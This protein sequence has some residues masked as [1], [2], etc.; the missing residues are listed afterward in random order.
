[1][2]GRRLV[3]NLPWYVPLPATVILLGLLAGLNVALSKYFEV[4][5]DMIWP[6]YLAISIV[7]MCSAVIGAFV[8]RLTASQQLVQ[9]ENEINSRYDNLK[10]LI[11]SVEREIKSIKTQSS[12]CNGYGNSLSLSISTLKQII[13]GEFGDSLITYEELKQI[14]NAIP[15]NRQIWVLTSALELED[16]ELKKVIISNFKR[17]VIYKYLIPAEDKVLQQ[18][19]KTLAIDWQQSSGLSV[20]Q[21][22]KQILCYLVPKH[23]VYMTVIIYDPFKTPP[24]VLVKFPTSEFYQKEKYPL[25]YRVDSKPKEAWHI[26][27]EAFQDLIDD[28]RKCSLTTPMVFEFKESTK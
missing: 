16:N 19:M 27:I 20:E 10:L 3:L 18:K 24:A 11:E 28:G 5:P 25:I 14:E 23:F 2:S 12:A 1:M 9:A 7:V 21:A 4:K 22:K 6:T 8:A 13:Q 26:F 15:D 17:G